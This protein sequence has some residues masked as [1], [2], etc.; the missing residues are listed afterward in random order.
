MPKSSSLG[1]RTKTLAAAV[2]VLAAGMGLV[3]CGNSDEGSATTTAADTPSTTAKSNETTTT[4]E[5]AVDV[6]VNVKIA[7]S[8]MG[9]VLSDGQG[10][11]FYIYTPDGTGAATC[12]DRGL[13][14]SVPA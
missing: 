1:S 6:G 2:V 11:V 3:S 10:R 13:R 12:V 5:A 4:T 7:S 14:K 8:G 9:D